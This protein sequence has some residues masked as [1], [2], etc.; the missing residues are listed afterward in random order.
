MVKFLTFWV[1]SLMIHIGNL[2]ISIGSLFSKKLQLLK[3]GRAST[4]QKLKDNNHLTGKRIWMH[5]A[6]LGEFEQ[7]RPLIEKIKKEQ[8]DIAVYLSFFSPSGYE[9]QKNYEKA[10]VIFYLPSDT[11]TNA[12]KLVHLIRPDIVIFVKYEFW[13]NLNHRL[14]NSGIP[15]VLISA[16][17]R[18]NDY[19]WHLL[20]RPFKNILKNYTHIF[21]QDDTSA[22][23]LESQGFSNYSVSGDTRI[24]RVT[25]RSAQVIQSEEIAQ[26]VNGKSAIVYGSVWMSDMHVVSAAIAAFPDYIHI[27]A[28]HD[29]SNK[30]IHL[31]RSAFNQP[32][33]LYSEQDWK[34]NVVVI[35]NIGML[36][37]LYSFAKY[38][39]IGGGFQKGI[40]NILE[41][42]VYKIPVFFGPNHKKFNEAVTLTSLQA[43]FVVD[44]REKMPDTI[45]NLDQNQKKYQ[46]IAQILDDFFEKNKGATEKTYIKINSLCSIQ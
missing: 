46:N 2:Y 3:T 32:S 22:R 13:W 17:F 41:P 24:D 40:H 30:N 27:I 33:D 6:S 19:F 14:I 31:I 4:W 8:P 10:D 45:K 12:K 43:A 20:S 39:Y 9:I 38:A 42:A 28:P 7:G 34:S 15:V 23:V 16:V 37:G 1:Y 11:G 29:I 5:C 44:N 36:A 21:T 25:Q 26:Y 18:P 35:N